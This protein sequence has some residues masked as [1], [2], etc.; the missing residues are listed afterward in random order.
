[1][2]TT[3]IVIVAVIATPIV[4]ACIF[5]AVLHFSLGTMRKGREV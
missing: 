4:V 2:L 1:M 5:H 3:V